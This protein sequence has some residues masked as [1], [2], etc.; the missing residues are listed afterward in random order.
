MVPET[1]LR[2]VVDW[3]TG[4]STPVTAEGPGARGLA[5]VQKNTDMHGPILEAMRLRPH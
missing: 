2:F 1:D 4:E 5:R 3:R